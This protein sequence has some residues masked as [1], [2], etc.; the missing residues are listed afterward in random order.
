MNEEEIK[1]KETDDSDVVDYIYGDMKVGVEFEVKV[2][3]MEMFPCNGGLWKANIYFSLEGYNLE[4]SSIHQMEIDVASAGSIE[5]TKDAI[6]RSIEKKI[7]SSLV[8]LTA[9]KWASI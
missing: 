3:S 6:C 5:G 4:G 2:L 1:K 9:P 7:H 8:K